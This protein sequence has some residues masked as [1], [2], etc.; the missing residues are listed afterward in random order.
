MGKKALV[1]GASRGIGRAVAEVLARRGYDLYL[2][3]RSR[4]GQL[5]ELKKKLEEEQGISC[6]AMLCNMGSYE[7]VCRLFEKIDRLDVL[8]NNAGISYVGLLSDMEVRQWE[9]II[10]TNLNSMFYTCSQAIPLMLKEQAGRIV[11]ISSIW[12]R[13]GASMEVA[14]SAAK[15]GVD[16]FTRALA[17]ELAPSHICVNALACGVIDTEMNACFSREERE[18]LRAE[19]PADRFGRP[20]EAAE[21]VWQIIESPE[22]MTGQIIGLDGG[23]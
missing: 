19:I 2:T 11:N 7:E 3:C 4:E 22:Y 1:S 21:M 5:L 13:V 10:N 18:L 12:G 9:E 15:G 16:S 8:V 20:E 6:T 23:W 17:K 14:Y